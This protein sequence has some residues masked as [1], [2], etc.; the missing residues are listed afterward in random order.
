MASGPLRHLPV[1]EVM[2]LPG[3]ETVAPRV[4]V[5]LRE[6]ETLREQ[7]VQCLDGT[8]EEAAAF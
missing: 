1:P 3:S 8:T 4:Q 6:R 7:G 5:R 2:P